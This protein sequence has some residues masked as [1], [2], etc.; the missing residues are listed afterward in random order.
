[1]KILELYSK[2][3]EQHRQLH[4][5]LERKSRRYSFVRL[6]IALVI[7]VMLFFGLWDL[8][9]IK[10][11]ILGLCGLAVI[12]FLCVAKLHDGVI[13][14]SRRHKLLLKINQEAGFRLERK[15]DVIPTAVIPQDIADRQVACDLDLFHIEENRASL[16]RL[17]ARPQT[18][19]GQAVLY[20]WLLNPAD[21]QTIRER[22]AAVQELAPMLTWRQEFELAGQKLYEKPHDPEP[23]LK[24][25]ED[26]PWLV[27]RSWLIW[28]ARVVPFVTFT[29]IVLNIVGL[30]PAITWIATA[31]ASLIFTSAWGGKTRSILGSVDWSSRSFSVYA[32]LF[33]AVTETAFDSRALKLLKKSMEAEGLAADRQMRRLNRINAYAEAR[34]YMIHFLLQ[35]FFFWDFH[36]L[37]AL[38]RWQ[39]KAG[40]SAR[41]W[42]RALGELE[43][44]NVLS[45]L[46]HDHPSWAVP[47]IRNGD[48]PRLQAEGIGHPLLHPDNCTLN[49]VSVGPRGTFLLITGSNMS[50]KSTLLRALGVNAVL[51]QAGGP[52]CAKSF[53]MSS[54]VL[55]SS[56]RI[57]DVLE[58]G[59]SYFM[60][61]LLRL[62]EI[63]TRA[64]ISRKN[65][66]RT[67][68]FLL[69]EIL[70]GTNVTE[71]Q[72]AVRRVIKYL[73][74]HGSIG[75]IATHDL[76]LADAE[77]LSEACRPFYFT[78]SFTDSESGSRM[79]F[80]YK[81]RPGVSPT[82]NAIKLLE[83]IGLDAS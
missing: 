5:A 67:V 1:M 46:G 32:N 79:T 2:R 4:N 35:A 74:A 47:K 55:G 51:A 72:V 43:A 44:L 60:A 53:E 75:A 7:I 14:E 48:N 71:R 62:K 16:V 50:G 56:F 6:L 34:Y 3:S 49:N 36:V 82:V 57:H 81:L 26:E 42:L 10:L 30:L 69:D 59:V 77:D 17:L 15:W 29:L 73:M 13:Q 21:P 70:L 68:L 39:S 22:Q 76:S 66:E 33:K 38:E 19:I 54:L 25:A 40:K 23:F 37:N 27:K 41:K 28:T 12:V 83:I 63:V 52:V 9:H 58:D 61:E 20:D 65:K 80:D 8:D 31:V 45:G 64:R 18:T 24:W 78:E 11:W